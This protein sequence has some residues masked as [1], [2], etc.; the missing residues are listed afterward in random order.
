MYNTILKGLCIM[1]NLIFL[2]G[3]DVSSRIELTNKLTPLGYNITIIGTE[4][5]DK[6]IKNGIKYKTYN[7][8]EEQNIVGDIKTIFNLRNIL[9]NIKE[10]TIVHAFDTKP[11][12]FLPLASIGLKNI[13]VSRTITGMGRIFSEK[14]I[15]NRFLV[16]IYNTIQ[17][18]IKSRVDFTVFQNDDDAKYFSEHKL[19]PKNRSKI[20]KSSGINL[21]TFSTEVNQN[22][23]AQL[24]NELSI[25]TTQKTFILISRMVK[26]KG[27]ITYLK[28]AKICHESGYKYNFLLVGQLDEHKSIE[29]DEIEEY[30]R[31][32]NYLGRRE[33]VKEL[34]A[35]SDIFILPTYYREGVPRVLLEASAMGLGLITTNMPGCKDVVQD[36]YNGK[37]IEINNENDLSSK[38]ICMAENEK[39]LKLYQENTKKKV[40]EFDLNLVVDNYHNVYKGL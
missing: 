13:K 15:K 30:S 4:Q 39:K 21:K 33:E 1:T 36:E 19:S 37:L 26:Q 11:T 28:A 23:V 3:V 20:I 38:M 31:Y 34:L 7:M 29:L 35:L 22:R 17:K 40:E 18:T 2:G 8:R 10:T 24:I 14:N 16:H 27:I 12:L 32:V 6:F 25:D 9:K 5:K